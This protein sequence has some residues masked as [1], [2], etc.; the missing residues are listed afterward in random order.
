MQAKKIAAIHAYGDVQL[1][2]GTVQS[3]DGAHY[4][5]SGPAGHY[6][7]QRAFSCFVEPQVGDTVLFSHDEVRKNHILSIIERPGNTSAN[8]KFPGNVTLDAPQGQLHLN[9]RQGLDLSSEQSINLLSEDLSLIAKKGLFNLDN[10]TAIGTRL[11]VKMDDVQTFA[12]TVQTVAGQLLQKLKN[13][14][15][16]IEGVD[17]TRAQDVIT[18]VKNLYSLRSRQAAIL[19]KKDIKVDAERIHMG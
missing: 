14:I 7:A 13:S 11:M 9:A 19:A 4:Q 2:Y 15:R 8:L 1:E 16:L 18:T 5:I 12:D 10:L 17:Q 3:S 6:D